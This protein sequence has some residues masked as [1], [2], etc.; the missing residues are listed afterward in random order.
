MSP[1]LRRFAVFFHRLLSA[2]H[3]HST[4]SSTDW[5]AI[6]LLPFVLLLRQWKAAA[7]EKAKERS[8]PRTFHEAAISEEA[9]TGA[10]DESNA[11]GQLTMQTDPQRAQDSSSQPAT[12][13]KVCAQGHK[14]THSVD[15]PKAV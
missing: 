5:I 2:L 10:D 1:I 14:T 8:L 15:H 11:M 4:C 7:A 6:V 9:T 13:S 3:V 12:S